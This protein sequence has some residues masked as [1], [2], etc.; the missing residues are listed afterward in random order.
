MF[1]RVRDWYYDITKRIKRYILTIKVDVY[2]RSPFYPPRAVVRAIWFRRLGVELLEFKARFTRNYEID[3]NHILSIVPLHWLHVHLPKGWEQ[4]V[5][6]ARSTQH[7]Y[8]KGEEG[9]E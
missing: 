8:E 6:Y 7:L 3:V 5:E 2:V 4:N 1:D 9:N